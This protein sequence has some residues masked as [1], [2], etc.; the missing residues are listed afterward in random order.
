MTVFSEARTD[1]S[2]QGEGTRQARSIDIR[3]G[4]LSVDAG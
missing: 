3:T 2:D 1:V 4:R